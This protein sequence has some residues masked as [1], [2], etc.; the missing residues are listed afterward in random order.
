[1][2][3]NFR[4]ILPFLFATI[5]IISCN[6]DQSIDT[7]VSSNNP[8]LTTIT[9]KSDSI[10]L[11]YLTEDKEAIF[12]SWTNPNYVYKSGPNSQNVIYT[13]EIDTADANFKSRNKKE[14]S[15]SAD[16]NISYNTKQFNILL[17]DLKLKVNT[18][19]KIDIRL[20]ATLNGN[21]NTAVYSVPKSFK[22]RPYN[23]PPKVEIPATG[24]LWV[25]G[26]AFASGWANPLAAPYI[27][28]QK[29]TQESSTLYTLVVNF[30]GG[31]N[32]KIIQEN[33]VWGT[34]YHKVTGNWASGTFEKKDADPGFDGPTAG[35]YK[36][37]VDF[38]TGT[39]NVIP[40]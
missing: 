5:L 27:T 33:G 39:Y 25:T 10:D 19:N 30:I 22:V 18:V 32:Y 23:P 8:I 4:K 12:L 40:Q 6:K 26:N 15:I 9:A 36:I 2:K 13:I 11:S 14:I 3:Q 24:T 17:A 31:G 21:N 16:L 38:Q 7:L 34:Q 29:F 28:S 37:T 20:K 35:R 1:M